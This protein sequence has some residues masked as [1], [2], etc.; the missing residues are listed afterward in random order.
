MGRDGE[1]AIS[2]KTMRPSKVHTQRL[3]AQLERGFFG[4]PEGIP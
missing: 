4:T 3:K 1:L 2:R